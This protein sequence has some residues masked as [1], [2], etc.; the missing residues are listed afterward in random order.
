MLRF[1]LEKP[2]F[3][4][5]IPVDGVTLTAFFF[6]MLLPQLRYRTEPVAANP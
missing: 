5:E 3:L 6:A 1:V 4:E 2:R